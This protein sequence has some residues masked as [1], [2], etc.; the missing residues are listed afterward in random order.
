MILWCNAKGD[1]FIHSHYSFCGRNP[2]IAY[3]ACTD[4]QMP[5][6]AIVYNSDF[7][8]MQYCR[9][10]TWTRLDGIGIECVEGDGI[11]MSSTGWVCSPGG[12]P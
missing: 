7:S 8:A 10:D 12:P 6:G 4:P 3:A 5:V 1:R 11:V 2:S 9:E